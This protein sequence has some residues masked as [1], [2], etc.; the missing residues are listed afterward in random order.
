MEEEERKEMS[1]IRIG[2]HI[3]MEKELGMV[4]ATS[5]SKKSAEKKIKDDIEKMQKEFGVKGWRKTDYIIL[6]RV[7]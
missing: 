7:K 6:K 1:V 3:V 4:I 2:Q 5:H